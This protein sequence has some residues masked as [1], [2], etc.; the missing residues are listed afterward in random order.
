MKYFSYGANMDQAHM[1]ATAPGATRL[2]RASLRGHRVSIGRA[3]FGTLVDDPL[4]EVLGVLW[5]LPP[6]DVLALDRFEGVPEGIYYRDRLPVITADGE[7]VEAMVYRATDSAPGVAEPGY[8]LQV[9][10]AAIAAGFPSSYLAV[11]T[12]LPNHHPWTP[13]CRQSS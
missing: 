9:L 12:A 13:P 3:G 1:G 8:L 11:L 7:R 4:G 10:T 2:G 6:E 5:D